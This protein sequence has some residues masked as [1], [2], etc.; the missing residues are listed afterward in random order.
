M[1]EDSKDDSLSG[2]A[3][4]LTEIAPLDRRSD[5]GFRSARLSQIGL[6]RNSSDLE[7]ATDLLEIADAIHARDQLFKSASAFPLEA[8]TRSLEAGGQAIRTLHQ[9]SERTRTQIEEAVRLRA[10]LQRQRPSRLHA[11]DT[12]G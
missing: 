12:S 2:Q 11:L 3:A 6:S 7:Q 10:G 4:G 5:A 8:L 9:L 1:P